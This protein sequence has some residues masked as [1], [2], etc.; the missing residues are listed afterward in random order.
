[1]R[2]SILPVPSIGIASTWCRSS[3]LGSQSRGNSVWHRRS[4]SVCGVMSGS[5]N[6]TTS[7]S[8]LTGSVIAVTTEVYESAS[9]AL[10]QSSSLTCGTISPPILLKR[11]RRSVMRMNPPSSI[12]AISPVTYQPSRKT[13]AVRSGSPRYPFMTLGPFTSSS[14]S[15]SKRGPSPV[16]ESTIFAATPGTGCPTEPDLVPR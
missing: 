2:R 7:R 3:R 6:N 1:M 11:D 10:T 13:S 9:V 15:R 14:P 12:V 8:P 5:V 16:T 4:Q